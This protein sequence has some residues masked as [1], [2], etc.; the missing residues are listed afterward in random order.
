MSAHNLLMLV[1]GASS[2][3]SYA[4][5]SQDGHT[6]IDTV[7]HDKNNAHQFCERDFISVTG[8]LEYV[9]DLRNKENGNPQELVI[10]AFKITDIEEVI[11][12]FPAIE[13]DYQDWREILDDARQYNAVDAG[14][15]WVIAES[16]GKYNVTTEIDGVSKDVAS[17]E[18][19]LFPLSDLTTALE[20][21]VFLE[22][23]YSAN[24]SQ[25]DEKTASFDRMYSKANTVL[26]ETFGYNKLYPK[27]KAKENIER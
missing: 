6:Y 14:R 20:M 24:N 3:V 15:A 9:L 4:V 27:E 19:D 23:V 21:V 10:K 7:F 26:S 5:S 2:D 1:N 22:R 16:G 8:A 17:I 11:D 18:N 25:V 13:Y 12:D